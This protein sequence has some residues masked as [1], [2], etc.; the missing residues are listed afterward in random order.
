MKAVEVRK[1]AREALK[2]KWKKGIG[3]ILVYIAITFV[4]G[5]ISGFFEEKPTLSFFFVLVEIM[6][7]VPLTFGLEFAFL[8][9]KRNENVKATDVIKIGAD[10]FSRCWKITGRTILKLI[11]PVIVFIGSMIAFFI[12]I[13]YCIMQAL[14]GTTGNLWI[15]MVIG[16]ILYL[17]AIIYYVSVSL[18]YSLTSY[19]AY[20]NTGMTALEIVNESAR[21]MKGNRW[22]IILLELSF[23][24]WAILAI[25][26]LGIGYLWLIPYMRMAMVCFYDKLAHS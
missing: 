8:K 11:L 15:P 10:N 24:G 2:G 22:K 16:V 21:L 23:I 14:A 7:S 20:D 26:T 19:I 6:I 13:T 18:L 9:L 25:F 17:I 5:L 1:E 3:I 4:F 12:I